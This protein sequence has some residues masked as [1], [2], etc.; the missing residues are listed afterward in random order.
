MKL[1][2]ILTEG[3]IQIPEK[4]YK[5]MADAFVYWYAAYFQ[6]F[7]EN[8]L[9]GKDY[10]KAKN[11]ISSVCKKYGVDEPSDDDVESAGAEKYQSIKVKMPVSD[12]PY[13]GKLKKFYPDVEMFGMTFAFRIYFKPDPAVLPRK[14]MARYSNGNIA[15]SIPNHYMD[16]AYLAQGESRRRAILTRDIERALGNIRHELTHAV[17]FEVLSRLHADQVKSTEDIEI[18]GMSNDERTDLYLLSPLEFDPQIKSMA[19]LFKGIELYSKSLLNKY[20]RRKALGYVT[21][22]DHTELT[23]GELEE[24]GYNVRSRFFLALKKRDPER[25]KRAVKIFYKLVGE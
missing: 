21:G 19:T 8:E 11:W 18:D 24:I 9:T 15:I 3:S 12:W 23:K 17:Q 4:Q 22:S 7:A 5:E 6:N 2:D 1:A 10:S 20:D 13:I 14:T 25:W 16:D